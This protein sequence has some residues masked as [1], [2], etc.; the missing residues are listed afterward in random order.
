MFHTRQ[1]R[2]EWVCR[3]FARGEW[4]FD[5]GAPLIG[6]GEV[7]NKLLSRMVQFSDS[8]PRT[9]YLSTNE[10]LQIDEDIGTA[11]CR[12]YVTA[13][14]QTETL[15]LQV[16]YSGEYLAEFAR[17]DNEAWY[18]VRLSISRPFYGDLGQHIRPV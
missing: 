8:T 17:D 2:S 10:D 6:R 7:R 15:P 11:Q 18:Y 14:Q 16:I 3:T 4:V 9:G 5:D 1:R 12:R 13:I